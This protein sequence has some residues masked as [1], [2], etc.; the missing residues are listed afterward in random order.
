MRSPDEIR[1]RIDELEAEYDRQDPP[2]SE[3]EDEHE[4]VLLRAIAELEWVL[5]EQ[6]EAPT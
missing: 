4:A 1:S 6:D 2:S 5:G 3:L